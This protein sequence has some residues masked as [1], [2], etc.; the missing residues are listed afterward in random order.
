M[1]YLEVAAV[2]TLFLSCT[3]GSPVAQGYGLP[4]YRDIGVTS[5]ASH[6]ILP[7]Q[8]NQ[9][10]RGQLDTLHLTR[11]HHGGPSISGPIGNANFGGPLI[12]NHGGHYGNLGGVGSGFSGSFGGSDVVGA[13]G[14]LGGGV[15]GGVGG[16]IVDGGLLG[17]S[18]GGIVDGGVV[19]G[20]YDGGVGDTVGPCTEGKVLQV[21]GSCVVP[22]VH[23]KVFVFAA[24]DRPK[25]I[26]PPPQLPK[27]EV[28]HNVVV[29]RS[30]EPE[31]NPEP[32][33]IPAPRVKN[34]LL[35][36]NKLRDNEQKVVQV[37]PQPSSAPSVYFVNYKDEQDL[38]NQGFQ[39]L[40]I[41]FDGAAG[42]GGAGGFGTGSGFG[43]GGG[44]GG[45]GGAGGFDN[46]GGVIGGGGSFG[47]VGIGVGSVG[48]AGGF[49][50]AGGAGGFGGAGGAGGFGGAGG[51]GGFGG[52]GGV[53]IG[54]GV[55]VVD[56]VDTSYGV[57]R[58][59]DV[60]DHIVGGGGD[61]SYAASDTEDVVVEAEPETSDAESPSES[62][63]SSK[64]LFFK[65]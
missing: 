4:P 13:G 53:G 44:V 30:Q 42:V 2:L 8:G 37:P 34:V 52:Y 56:V 51:A 6:N 19:G 54:G 29:I 39:G 36:L 22:L 50:G 27:P 43:S 55:D 65:A 59:N 10:G 41:D 15:V 31:E 21:D 25:V 1:E 40:G 28:Q 47:G 7:S 32:I 61:L 46:V 18:V 23:R 60:S 38:Q 12:S 5:F 33:V 11:T 17:G 3:S 48:G 57:P 62:E 45:A 9:Y 63:D 24:P 64:A 26:Q 35:V 16:D 49:G 14:G 58:V 20:S